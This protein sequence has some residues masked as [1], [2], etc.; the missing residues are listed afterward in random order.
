MKKEKTI[1]TPQ[2][3]IAGN[4]MTWK[5]SALQ[6]SNISSISTVPL[7]LMPFPLWAILMLVL[8][9]VAFAVSVLAAISIIAAA[10]FVIYF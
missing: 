5:S 8:G 2:L 6:L 10:V 9:S 3:F 1:V 4:I 7:E